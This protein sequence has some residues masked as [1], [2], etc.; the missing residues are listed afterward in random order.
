MIRSAEAR[1]YNS[2]NSIRQAL[3][4]DVG[5]L[6]N[7]EYVSQIECRGFLVP[8]EITYEQFLGDLPSYIVGEVGG[9]VAGFL[10]IEDTQEMAANETPHWIDP[11]MES[12]YWQKPHVNIGKIAVHP[13]AKRQGIASALMAEAERHARERSTP[14]IFSFIACCKPPTNYPSIKFHENHGFKETAPLA[15]LSAFG[16]RD[17]M[18]TLYSKK[19]I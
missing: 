16:I 4:L 5:R 12:I 2:I 18:A 8:V 9:S 19:L 7:P 14:Y 11:A 1:D 10:R 13:M 17:Y 3:T 6:S 15:P